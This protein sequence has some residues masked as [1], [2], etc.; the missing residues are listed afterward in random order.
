V[1]TPKQTAD[2]NRQF[3]YCIK[4]WEIWDR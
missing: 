4:G 3:E 1:E 2:K